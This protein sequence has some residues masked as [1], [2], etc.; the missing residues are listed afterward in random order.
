MAGLSTCIGAIAVVMKKNISD[1]YLS[2]SLAFSAGVMIFVSFNEIL[3]EG[4]SIMIEHYGGDKWMLIAYGLF[5]LGIILTALIDKFVPL[6]SNPH[7]LAYTHLQCPIDVD[8]IRKNKLTRMGLFTAF[9]IM[10]HNFPEGIATF[11]TSMNDIRMGV[12]IALAV[13]LHNIPEG[14]VVSVPIYCGT[15]SKW[16]AFKFAAISGLAEPLGALVTY[17]ILM[18]YFSDLMYGAVMSIV[19]GI[20]VYIAF[21][22]LLPAAQE[23]GEHHI[24]IWSLIAGMLVMALSLVII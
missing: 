3:P 18:P 12:P 6:P 7:E 11:M 10:L 24:A 22:E 23:Y 17:L 5:F 2:I 4:K 13:A 8:E 19:A 20:M 21:D 16:Q 9:V 1:T 14:I 15:G